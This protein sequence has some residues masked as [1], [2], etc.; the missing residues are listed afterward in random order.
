VKHEAAPPKIKVVPNVIGAIG[1]RHPVDGPLDRDGSSWTNDTFTSRKL[2][3][4]SIRRKEA[5]VVAAPKAP[6]RPPVA[7][8]KGGGKAKSSA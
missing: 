3:D 2:L 7:D 1:L 5:M 8:E 6:T 4:G